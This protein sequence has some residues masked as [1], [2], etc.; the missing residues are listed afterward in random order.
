MNNKTRIYEIFKS[1]P[2][3]RIR[4]LSAFTHEITIIHLDGLAN[5]ARLSDFVTRSIIDSEG[6]FDLKDLE[7]KSMAIINLNIET[8]FSE[9]VT[10]LLAGFSLLFMDSC[11]DALVLDTQVFDGRS[12]IEPPTSHVTKGPREGFVENMRTNINLMRKRLKSESFKQIILTAGKYTCTAISVC[13]LEG[14]IDQ[15]VV[16]E[17][18]TK[19]KNI[20]IDGIIDSSYVA[21][22]I[23]TCRS[24]L[25]KTVGNTEKPDI[26]TAKMLEGRAIIFVDGSPIA[27]TLPYMFIEDIQTAE[28]YYM[29]PYTAT[30]ARYIRL[31]S[32]L[33]SI[34][35][36]GLYVSLQLHNYQI[37]PLKFLLTIMNSTQAIPLS[38]LSEMIV[39]LIL[40]DV[41]R[42]ANFRMPQFAGLALSV[43]G[44]I[45]L[46]DAAVR[47]GILGA[48]AVMIGALSGIG[49]YTMPDN[50]MLFT[51][52]R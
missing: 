43:V 24:T 35:I 11:L 17:I 39:V 14:V 46:G 15:K 1:D 49:L 26:A 4:E 6:F 10:K 38:P 22:F 19:I 7:S 31:L 51:L 3:L 30:N 5:F 32:V 16:D 45:V 8:S 23:D 44:G 21:K 13:Y 27:L 52:L 12:I 37:I 50:T 20:N 34:F 48:P 47:A 36:P 28:D 33:G 41:L 9:M 42:E 25:F 18:V 40:F 2:D 29:S